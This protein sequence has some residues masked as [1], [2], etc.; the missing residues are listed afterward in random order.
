MS[1][2]VKTG[3]FDR[4]PWHMK[5]QVK[6]RLFS[7][8]ELIEQEMLN[9]EVAKEETFLHDGVRALG[10]NTVLKNSRVPLGVVMGNYQVVQNVDAF[11][12]VDK[13]LGTGKAEL[14]SAFALGKGEVIVVSAKIKNGPQVAGDEREKY[15]VVANSHD[16]S[17]Q[18]TYMTTLVQVVCYNTLMAA[19][20]SCDNKRKIRHTGNINEK[21]FNAEQFMKEV[22]TG[23]EQF[24]EKIEKLSEQPFSD[25]EFKLLM[26]MLEPPSPKAL[27]SGK[28]SDISTRKH[29]IWKLMQGYWDNGRGMD[30]P[31]KKNTAYGAISAIAEYADFGKTIRMTEKNKGN[32]FAA[33]AT[34][35][36]FG[37]AADMKRESM[38]VVETILEER[39]KFNP[40]TEGDE[41]F[42]GRLMEQVDF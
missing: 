36:L 27:K 26:G 12:S 20:H 7:V 22:I 3:M 1:D 29:N 8:K 13:I 18:L 37:T 38:S 2:R 31:L 23:I 34:S 30:H 42:V 21:M 40:K 6:D 25:S 10:F 5:G 41:S 32:A 15:L 4:V 19:L 24:E 33:N 17:M 11:K 35:T 28:Q 16:T 39:E 9:E 14:N